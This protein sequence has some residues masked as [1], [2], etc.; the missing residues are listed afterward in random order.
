MCGNAC[1]AISEIEIDAGIDV[2]YDRRWKATER[3]AR[4]LYEQPSL[5]SDKR[6]LI[7]GAGAGVE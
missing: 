2:Y 1:A 6:I 7:L 4:L 3:F 5:V